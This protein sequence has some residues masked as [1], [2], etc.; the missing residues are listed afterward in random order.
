MEP[1][2]CIKVVPQ[3]V[4]DPPTCRLLA[5]HRASSA[6]NPL[7]LGKVN[8]IEPLI[9]WSGADCG[10]AQKTCVSCVCSNLVMYVF[11]N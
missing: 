8:A 4:V 1:G 6:V 11:V 7:G 3:R 10:D 2:N 9:L 5:A